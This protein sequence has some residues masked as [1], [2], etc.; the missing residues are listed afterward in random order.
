MVCFWRGLLGS[1]LILAAADRIAWWN[2]DL[3]TL[4]FRNHSTYRTRTDNKRREPP[5]PSL[6]NPDE[7]EPSKMFSIP[8]H[9]A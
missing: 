1:V 7:P 3:K 9:F 6:P 2:I 5:D 4:P 8:C